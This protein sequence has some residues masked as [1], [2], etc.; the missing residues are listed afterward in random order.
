MAVIFTVNLSFET[1][2]GTG[3]GFAVAPAGFVYHPGDLSQVGF[4]RKEEDMLMIHEEG[5]RRYAMSMQ[6]D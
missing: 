4:V 2:A 6:C 5:V 1:W 3:T